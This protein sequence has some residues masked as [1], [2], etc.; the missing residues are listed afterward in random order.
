MAGAS[1]EQ[2]AVTGEAQ[3]N[4]SAIQTLSD[5]ILEKGRSVQSTSEATHTLAAQLKEL[6]MHF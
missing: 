5:D 6:A 4:T 2:S 1:E 3:R